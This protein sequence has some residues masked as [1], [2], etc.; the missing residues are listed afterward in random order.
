MRKRNVAKPREPRTNRFRNLANTLNDVHVFAIIYRKAVL[1]R[2]RSAA[3]EEKKKEAR[4]GT[5]EE[6]GSF[7]SSSS[8]T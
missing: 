6:C 1:T 4:S 5:M 2:M 7:L 3:E 8:A